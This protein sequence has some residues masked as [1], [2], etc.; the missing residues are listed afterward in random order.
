M[1]PGRTRHLGQT[2]DRILHLVGSRHH[3]IRQL[4][5]NDNDLGH[6]FQPDLLSLFILRK[7]FALCHRRL[8]S[9][10]RYHSIISMKISHI[11]LGK[12]LVAVQ[13]FVY[14][15]VQGAR[16]LS[17][18][19]DHRHQ[20]VGNSIINSQLHHLGVYHQKADLAGGGFIKKTDNQRIDAHRFT[21]ASGAGDQQVGHFCQ[22]RQ[23]HLSGNIPAQGNSQLAFRQTEAVGFH[24]FPHFHHI[25]HL[26]RHLDAHRRFSRDWSLDTDAGRR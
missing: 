1:H 4:V 21:G 14:C 7:L 8:S 2:A 25:D 17:R 23:G 13:H 24:Q 6:F 15:P 5:D 18:V 20:Q 22:I 12:N 9:V 11:V 3:Q 10:G 19:S 26:I 16:R